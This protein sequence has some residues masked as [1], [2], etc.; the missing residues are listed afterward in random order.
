[1]QSGIMS[2]T[3]YRSAINYLGYS[4]RRAGPA[5]GISTRQS[6]YYASGRVEVPDTIAYLIETMIALQRAREV[7]A[8][9]LAAAAPALDEHRR[10]DT[11]Q[12]SE[13]VLEPL[14]PELCE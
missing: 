12:P 6:Q 4:I 13:K 9:L 2:R 3:Q 7:I 8:A 5:L 14:P 11:P 1:M 10:L